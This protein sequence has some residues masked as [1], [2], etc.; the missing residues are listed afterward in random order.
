MRNR[1]QWMTCNPKNQIG[2][3]TKRRRRDPRIRTPLDRGPSDVWHYN[4]YRRSLSIGID[5]LRNDR[6]PKS[7]S[8]YPSRYNIFYFLHGMLRT[9]RKNLLLPHWGYF[10]CTWS[11]VEESFASTLG[12]VLLCLGPSRK[13]LLP[14]PWGWCS[15]YTGSTVEESSASLLGIIFLSL[16][17]LLE[18][19]LG[20]TCFIGGRVFCF[21]Y[22]LLGGP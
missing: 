16:C 17:D 7:L 14:L 4:I 12:I 10:R 1:P 9:L 18:M 20:C 8:H 6:N 22:C 21:L 19:V 3:L 5:S 15:R 11:I 2:S 13:N